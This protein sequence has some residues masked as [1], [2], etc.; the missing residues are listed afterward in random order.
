[1]CDFVRLQAGEGKKIKNLFLVFLFYFHPPLFAVHFL[2]A[3]KKNP[4]DGK[5]KWTHNAIAD[6]NKGITKSN[7]F[8]FVETKSPSLLH[9][10]HQHQHRHIKST[11]GD[12]VMHFSPPS[13]DSI[14]TDFT[15][16]NA[17][18]E[19]GRNSV[20]RQSLLGEFAV[21]ES[22]VF[23]F[24]ALDF[25][26]RYHHLRF[27]PRQTVT[28]V[29]IALNSSKLLFRFRLVRWFCYFFFL[30]W[31]FFLLLAGGE[32]GNVNEWSSVRMWNSLELNLM[33]RKLTGCTFAL[34]RH[35]IFWRRFKASRIDS[36]TIHWAFVS[37][38]TFRS[39][40]AK[41]PLCSTSTI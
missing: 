32:V 29:I 4:L 16:L 20:S 11:L 37:G 7:E 9:L 31:R 34:V 41:P 12:A 28:F 14:N 36:S 39:Q 24:L 22:F 15:N 17:I 33:T 6:D 30:P 27:C 1:M 2:V 5:W 18:S 8:C 23:F 25:P 38:S 21:G 35:W 13:K 3:I 10:H 26:Q 19:S 40:M